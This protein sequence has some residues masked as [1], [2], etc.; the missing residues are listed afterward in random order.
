MKKNLPRI[1]PL[2]L[3]RKREPF[4]QPDF[5][6]ELKHDGFR[7]VAYIEDGQSKLI[8]RRNNILK[9]FMPLCESLKKLSVRNAILDGELICVD[10]N[11][12]SLFNELM[13]RRG[14]PYFYAFDLL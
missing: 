1:S 7:A 4:D 2:T 3:S 13:F 8:S 10:G 11:G 12:I 5:I 9:S 6:F 14:Q